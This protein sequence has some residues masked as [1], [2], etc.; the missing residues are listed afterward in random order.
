MT[1][2]FE[3]L[4]TEWNFDKN[5][6]IKLENF[7]KGSG[8]K[9][10]WRCKKGHEWEAS[11]VKRYNGRTCPYCAHR[12]V[13]N[14]SSLLITHPEIAKEWNYHKNGNLT[15]NKVSYGSQKKVWWKCEKGHEW[16]AC[17]ALRTLQHICKCPYC[18]RRLVSED[19]NLLKLYPEL[20]KEWNHKKNEDLTPDKVTDKFITKVWWE[21]KYGHEWKATIYSR[22]NDG[23]GCSRCSKQCKTSQFEIRVFSELKTLFKDAV[24]RSKVFNKECDIY[25]KSLNLAIETDGSHWHKKTLEKDKLK[26]KHLQ[27]HGVQIWRI[28]TYPLEKISEYDIIH[29]DDELDTIKILVKQISEKFNIDLEKYLKNESFVNE[30]EFKQLSNSQL[31]SNGE[32]IKDINPHLMIEWNYEKN[33]RLNPN[34]ISF[35]SDRKIWWKCKQGH[36]WQANPKSRHRGRNCPYCAGQKTS[37]EKSL[38]TLNKE[39]TDEW[40]QEMNLLTPKD[41]LPYSNK[42]V[43]WKCKHGHVWNA[44]VGTRQNGNGCPFCAR[45]RK[46]ALTM[47]YSNDSQKTN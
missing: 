9:V 1:N 21:C 35:G 26:N 32:S 27:Q 2:S 36:E 17:I 46:S 47:A 31:V 28:R 45:K 33:G 22:A 24:Q 42:K 30:L 44:S 38:Y 25:I 13:H 23:N 20:S 41:V 4:L 19:N 14:D 16:K 43:W 3:H 7:S 39:L 8:K 29:Y 6:N 40:Y 10:W 11:I 5:V 15:P 12:K 37:P 18:S 34:D